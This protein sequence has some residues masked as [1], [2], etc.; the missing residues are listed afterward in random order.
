MTEDDQLQ[1]RHSALE[2][3]LRS[4]LLQPLPDLTKETSEQLAAR[5]RQID[6]DAGL[7]RWNIRRWD[8]DR[9]TATRGEV[10]L[11]ELARRRQHVLDEI[12]RREQHGFRLENRLLTGIGIFLALVAAVTGVIAILK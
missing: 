7:V 11:G 12:T 2:T 5:L 3:R 9:P 4:D 8:T 10:H 6:E 1:M